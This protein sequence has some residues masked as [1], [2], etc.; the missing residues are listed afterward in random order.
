MLGVGT[1]VGLL[2][3]AVTVM[4]EVQMAEPE[5]IP[6]RLMFCGPPFSFTTMLANESIVGGL[7]AGT[8]LTV[9]ERMRVLLTAPP[10][11][12]S[13]VI[14]ADPNEPAVDVKVRVPFVSGLE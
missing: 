1:K 14:T 4:L 13:T 8:T 6:V 2:E 3:A 7:L 10:S 5:E 12:T 11:S 9:K